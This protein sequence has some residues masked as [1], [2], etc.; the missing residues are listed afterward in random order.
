MFIGD[1][2]CFRVIYPGDGGKEEGRGGRQGGRQIGRQGAREGY[3]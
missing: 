1:I 3:I 2:A